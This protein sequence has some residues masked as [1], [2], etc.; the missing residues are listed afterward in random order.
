[1]TAA[2]IEKVNGHRPVA[3]HVEPGFDAVTL[4]EA[5][6]IRSRAKAEADAVKIKAAEEAERQRLENEKQALANRRAAIRAEREEAEHANKM[7]KLRNE[8]EETERRTRE[9][10]RVDDEKRQ[11]EKQATEEV[12]AAES[13]W[14][15]MAL[16]FY[17]V[18]AIVALPVQVAAFW[19]PHAPWLIVAPLMLEGGAWVVLKGAAAAVAGH[20]PHWHYRMIAWL[21]AFLAAGINLWHGLNAFDPATAIGTAFASVAGPGVWDLHEHGRIRK[22][23]GVLTRAERKAQRNAEKRRAAEKKAAEQAAKVAQ[24]QLDEARAKA[25]PKVWE[26]ALKI[27]AAL[28][29][30][31]VTETVWK[32]AHRD[33]EG[34]DPAESAEIIRLRNAAEA[35][36]EAARQK[37]PVRGSS[38]QVT[39]QVP[40]AKKPRVYNP[41][42]RRGK[43]TKGDVKYTPGASRQASIT[44]RNAARKEGQA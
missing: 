5:D 41:P 39:S 28:G 18:C 2:P 4:A 27:A 16:G 35:R 13:K 9:A 43:R 31:T 33:I 1:M 24:A 32:R 23:D 22:R 11:A 3:S 26:H 17:V 40:G 21:L 14:R 38:P 6:A 10:R 20:R 7:A 19:N 44:A 12:D 25:F 8:R 42:A 15:H 36:V 37:R 30:T 29:E 34:A